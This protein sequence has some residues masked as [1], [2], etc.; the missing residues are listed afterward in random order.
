MKEGKN[1][2][3]IVI[4]AEKAFANFQHLFIKKLFCEI[5]LEGTFLNLIEFP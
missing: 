4:N 3:M 5:R 2:M 1:H